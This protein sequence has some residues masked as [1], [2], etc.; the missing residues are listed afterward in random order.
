MVVV[1]AFVT[2]GGQRLVAGGG[3]GLGGRHEV[4][5]GLQQVLGGLQVVALLPQ[6]DVLVLEVGQLL[7]EANEVVQV[8]EAHAGVGGA[9]AGRP[10]AA[11]QAGLVRTGYHQ[12]GGLAP[13]LHTLVLLLEE[14]D[15]VGGLRPSS[16][17]SDLHTVLSHGLFLEELH[18]VGGVLPNRLLG[19]LNTQLRPGRSLLVKELRNVSCFEPRG[20][21]AVADGRWTLGMRCLRCRETF[22]PVIFGGWFMFGCWCRSYSS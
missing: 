6:L 5:A 9:G 16:L 2:F 1:V 13:L 18:H 19:D 21:S 15:D 12:Q 11:V 10:G 14:L 17:R 20:L 22:A 7:H 8:V 3:G 4:T